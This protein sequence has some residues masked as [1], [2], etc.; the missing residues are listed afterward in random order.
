M[1][2]DDMSGFGAL[3]ALTQSGI[4]VPDQVS[5]IGFDDI[6]PASLYNPPMTTIRQPLGLMGQMAVEIALQAIKGGREAKDR[7]AIH[8]RFPP[9]LVVRESTKALVPSENARKT[10]HADDMSERRTKRD[11]VIS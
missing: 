8:R 9:E 1:A 3:R 11:L 6:A 7:A 10:A 5:V 2:F 4:A